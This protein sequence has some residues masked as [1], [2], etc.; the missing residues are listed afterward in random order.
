MAGEQ[1]GMKGI[2]G[3]QTS[4]CQPAC[5]LPIL[6]KAILLLI[7]DKPT[8]VSKLDKAGGVKMAMAGGRAGDVGQGRGQVGRVGQGVRLARW[9]GGLTWFVV[10]RGTK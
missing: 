2:D 6:A 9:L 5:S 7:A 10:R 3:S 1:A 8:L 4:V